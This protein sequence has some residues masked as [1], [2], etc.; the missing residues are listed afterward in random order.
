MKSLMSKY[1]T[2]FSSSLKQSIAF[3]YIFIYLCV[4]ILSLCIFYGANAVEQYTT[5]K[6]TSN[7]MQSVITGMLESGAGQSQIEMQLNFFSKQYNCTISLFANQ[8]VLYTTDKLL[9]QTQNEQQDSLMGFTLI[10]I[11]PQAANF[12]KGFITDTRTVSLHSSPV[13]TIVFIYDVTQS[14][15]AVFTLLRVLAGCM[16]GGLLIMMI[17]SNG[18]LARLLK[19]ISI[20]SKEAETVTAQNLS[21]RL[22]EEDA[23]YELKELVRTINDMLS[24]LENAAAKQQQFVSDVSH[25]MRTPLAVISG[26]SDMLER[27]GKNDEGILDEG[28]DA[29]KKETKNMLELIEKLLILVRYDKATMKYDF[30]RFDVSVLIEEIAKECT[31]MNQD[32]PIISHIEKHLF[33]YADAARVKQAVRILTD[34]AL[35]Y[36]DKDQ[37][38]EI[39]LQKVANKASISIRDY[40]CGISKEDL[41]HI[42]D[43]FYRCDDSRTKETGGHGLGLSIAKALV[44]DNKGEITVMSKLSSGTTF[45]LEFTLDKQQN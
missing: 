25:E 33:I 26:Y 10:D 32:H 39:T 7:D 18:I 36:S 6:K 2:R 45:T 21:M 23:Q 1:K 8:N 41:P 20:I 15:N 40:G 35:K 17:V 29:I 13:D 3:S 4:C 43:R 38:I 22:N 42:F 12:T 44:L 31:L 37:P 34:N 28:I 24:R 5:V 14:R 30:E 19:P 16:I 27:W 11:F 9:S